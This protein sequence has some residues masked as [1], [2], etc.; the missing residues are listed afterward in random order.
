MYAPQLSG[1][2]AGENLDVVAPCYLKSADGKLYMCDATL[3]DEKAECVGFTPRAVI[4]GQPV[5]LYGLGTRFRYGSGLTPGDYFYLATTAGRLDTV[6][7]T[8]DNI[9]LPGGFGATS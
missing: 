4:S 8:G 1:L 2:L 5:T 7:Q 6:A 9:G 3:A